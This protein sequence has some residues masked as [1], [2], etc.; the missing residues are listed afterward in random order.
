[1]L[2]PFTRQ[3]IK[4]TCLSTIGYAPQTLTLEA[5]FR[6]GGLY[7]YFGVSPHIYAQLLAAP[8]KGRFFVRQIK[9]RYPFVQVASP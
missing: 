5:R 9:G 2:D 3:S 7:W 1:M 4:S 8:S 6:S